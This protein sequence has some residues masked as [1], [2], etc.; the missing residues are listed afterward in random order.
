MKHL[1]LISFLFLATTTFGQNRNIHVRTYQNGDSSF[2][3]N[4][5]MK[6]RNQLKLD[7]IQKTRNN[8]YFRLWIDERL[9]IDIWETP[10]GKQLGKITSWTKEITPNGEEPTNRIYHQTSSL[11]S[12][13][14]V[15][16][17]TLIKTSQISTIPDESYFYDWEPADDGDSYTIERA[18]SIDYYFKTYGSPGDQDSIREAQ[19]VQNFVDRALEITKA[20]DVWNDFSETIPFEGFTTS[21]STAIRLILSPKEQKRFKRERDEYRKENSNK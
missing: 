21:G 20:S 13:Q 10:N 1:I 12:V 17:I 2:W 14:V 19:I 3:Y 6:L 7:D 9:A 4:W 5:E 16:F 11:D 18:D 8:W 15:K